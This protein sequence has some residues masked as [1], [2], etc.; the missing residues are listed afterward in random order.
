MALIAPSIL[1]ADFNNLEQDIK[2]IC[3]ADYV[4]IDVMDGQ[5]VPNIT[6]GPVVIKNLK[7]ITN[8]R[9]DVHL[10]IVNP[11]NFIQDFRNAGA[12][13]ITVHYEASNHLDRLINQ[14]KAS[15][16]KAGV[17]INPA[18]PVENI[19]PVLGMVDLVLIMSVN[20][21]FGGQKFIEYTLEKVRTLKNKIK[22]LGLQT[23]IEIDG[24][25][26]I[27]NAKAITEAGVDIL[28]AGST[29]FNSKNIPETISILKN[30]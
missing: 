21:G 6:I 19:F 4:H 14:I 23:L 20:P 26:T 9:L 30:A 7:K 11:E 16:A 15:G 29:I 1:S 8:L 12:D 10:M 2:A 3:S 18:T 5:F 13:I 22:E 25:V 28:V 27:E 24:G 17:S